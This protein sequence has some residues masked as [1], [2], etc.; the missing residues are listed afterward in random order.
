M[1]FSEE[2]Q[3]TRTDFDQVSLSAILSEVFILANLH[4]DQISGKFL[5]KVGG[6]LGLW[7]GVGALQASLLIVQYVPT[8]FNSILARM[9]Q[10][11]RI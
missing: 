11:L 1:A 8:I 3:V 6:S 2:V 7:L 10:S 9:K 4:C 5:S